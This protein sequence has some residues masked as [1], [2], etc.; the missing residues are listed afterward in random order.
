MCSLLK[1][2]CVL[3]GG[4]PYKQEDVQKRFQEKDRIKIYYGS[5]DNSIKKI[6]NDVQRNGAIISPSEFYIDQAFS[7]TIIS[8]V[9]E[10]KPMGSESNLSRKKSL[11]KV[12]WSV[13]N[14]NHRHA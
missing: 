4:W 13:D 3:V 2:A 6:G 7:N 11:L 12:A 8:M 14:L 10:G 9:E 1:L 5:H